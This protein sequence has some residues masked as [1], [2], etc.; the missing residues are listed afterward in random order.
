VLKLLPE[1][2]HPMDALAAAVAAMGTFYPARNVED[3]EARYQST[4]RLIA[5]LPTLVAAIARIRRGDEPIAPRDD[6]D[7]AANFLYMLSDRVPDTTSAHSLDVCM[8]LHAEHAMNAST[9]SARITGSTFAGPFGVISAAVSALGGPLHGGAAE[10]CLR[11]LRSLSSPDR[12]RMW[13]EENMRNQ[14][15]IPGFGHRVYKVKDPRAT[16][17]QRLAM[18][19]VEKTGRSAV[20]DTAVELERVVTA[21]L[22]SKGVYPNVDFFNGVVYDRLGIAPEL[23]S[24]M[25]AMSRVAGWLAHWNEQVQKNHLIRPT[26]VY[27]GEREKKWAAAADR[28]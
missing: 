15:I 21:A 6:L 24:C 25:F 28:Y 14:Q 3:P 11:L 23:F 7:H 4:I 16:I 20:Y 1:T 10:E 13:A 8:I 19:L 27:Q 22:G 17:L 5:K 26:Q 9:F 12:A 18:Q 2:G